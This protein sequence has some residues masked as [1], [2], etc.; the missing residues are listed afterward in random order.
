MPVRLRKAPESERVIVKEIA[1]SDDDDRQ[2]NGSRRDKSAIKIRILPGKKR[3][4]KIGR[5]LSEIDPPNYQHCQHSQRQPPR[6]VKRTR[7]SCWAAAED[8]NRLQH[9]DVVA[10]DVAYWSTA[11][12]ASLSPSLSYSDCCDLDKV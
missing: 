6:T 4:P 3:R 12:T 1:V 2:S 10:H 5:D 9:C 11:A 7:F 8:D